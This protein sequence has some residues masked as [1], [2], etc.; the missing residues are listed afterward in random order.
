MRE[1]QT[2]HFVPN[3]YNDN[4]GEMG[5]PICHC[6][7]HGRF[8]RSLLPALPE[9]IAKTRRGVTCGNCKRTKLF[10]KVR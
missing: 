4:R 5:I 10:R 1:K 2:K 6:F 9:E 7:G 3:R 8:T